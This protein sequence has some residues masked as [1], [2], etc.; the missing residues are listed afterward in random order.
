ATG[1]RGNPSVKVLC[2]DDQFVGVFAETGRSLGFALSL[3]RRAEAESGIPDLTAGTASD[4]L[5]YARQPGVSWSCFLI[6]QAV[7][8]S[9][10]GM[11]ALQRRNA[12]SEQACCCSG[13]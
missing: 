13:V 3:G 4:D 5:K 7:M 8:R 9:T 11:S 10:S 1:R 6:M 12:S 2:A